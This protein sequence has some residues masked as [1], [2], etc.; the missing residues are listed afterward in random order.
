MACACEKRKAFEEL[1]L[2]LKQ[3][4]KA[5]D[6]VTVLQKAQGL[7]GYLSHELMLF[8]AKK[9]KISAAKVFGVASFYSQFRLKPVGKNL[10]LLCQGTAC[11]VG[12]SKWIE[13]SIKDELGILEGEISED[14]LFSFENVAC[15]GCCSLA[16]A[17]MINGKTYGN[18]T[19]AFVRKILKEMRDKGVQKHE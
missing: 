12:G 2:T 10:I 11:H 9:M 7:Y 5:S 8:V 6:L 14:G 13:E 18:L 17:L 19:P 15:L 16:P 4:K 1:T 3:Y